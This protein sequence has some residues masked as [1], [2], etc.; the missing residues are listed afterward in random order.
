MLSRGVARH[1]ALVAGVLLCFFVYMG[2]RLSGRGDTAAPA[3]DAGQSIEIAGLANQDN[4]SSLM[5]VRDAPPT[6]PSPVVAPIEMPSS[7]SSTRPGS[8]SFSDVASRL[9][10]EGQ[11]VAAPIGAAV[12]APAAPVG[13]IEESG[14]AGNTISGLVPAPLNGDLPP[15]IAQDEG[16]GAPRAPLPTSSNAGAGGD[17]LRPSFNDPPAVGQLRPQPDAAAASA[18]ASAPSMPMPPLPQSRAQPVF[19]DDDTDTQP[20]GRL[21]PPTPPQA[22]RPVVTSPPAETT[23]ATRLPRPTTPAAETADGPAASDS[24]RIYVIRP[25]D[26]LSRIATRELGSISLADNI[27]LLNRDVILDRDHLEVGQKIRL[28]VLDTLAGRNN[29]NGNGYGIPP[30]ERQVPA[31]G[32]GTPAAGPHTRIHRVRPG[33]TLSSI[34]QYYYGSSAAWQFV[35]EANSATLRNPNQLSVGMELSIPPYE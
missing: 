27:F 16:E 21:A 28:P 33:D 24:L 35:F 13:S 15:L 12:S 17:A 2:Y 1:L 6:S 26:T 25:G 14:I 29:A 5:T 9:H 10:T 3:P 22:T 18:S 34:A 31:A 7:P 11:P 8:E 19:G 32:A 4:A 23:P 20:S 30:V